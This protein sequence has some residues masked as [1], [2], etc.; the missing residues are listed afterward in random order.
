M[1]SAGAIST[2]DAKVKEQLSSIRN[3]AGVYDAANG[4]YGTDADCQAGGMGLDTASGMVSLMAASSWP[5]GTAPTCS[6]DSDGVSDATQY[7]AYHV[8]SDASYWCIDST[9][10]SLAEASGW[11]APTGGDA[12]P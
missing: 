1:A 8:L 12:C 9:G 10:Q 7:S 6:T 2:N 11:T 4:N 3:A 5:D